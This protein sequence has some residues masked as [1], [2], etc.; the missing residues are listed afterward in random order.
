MPQPEPRKP[1]PVSDKDTKASQ[2]ETSD[3]RAATPP[4]PSREP[5]TLSLQDQVLPLSLPARPGSGLASLWSGQRSGNARSN[6]MRGNSQHQTLEQPQEHLGLPDPPTSLSRRL[7]DEKSRPRQHPSGGPMSGP[8]GEVELSFHNAHAELEREPEGMIFQPQERLERPQ[9]QRRGTSLLDRLSTGNPRPH[10]AAAQ[11]SLRDRIIPSK[12]DLEDMMMDEGV[13]EGS[14]D[15]ED[16]IESKRARR[17][18]GRAR[19]RGRRG[20]PA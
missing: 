9:M 6:D 8:D 3:M 20:G 12:R 1:S 16:G 5:S 17:K 7:S 13:H 15:G 11:Q 2:S 10:D 18:N 14:F 4:P 19:T